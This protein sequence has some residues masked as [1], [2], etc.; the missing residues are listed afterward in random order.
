MLFKVL[1]WLTDY[2]ARHVYT[3]G[4]LARIRTIHFARW[5]LLDGGRTAFFASNYDGSHQAYMDDFINKVWWGLNIVFSNGLGYPRTRWL[6]LD[7]ARNE[8]RFKDTNRRHQIATQ[9]W[10][11]AYPGLT[12]VDLA[13]NTRVRHAFQQA[14]MTD[15]EIRAWLK[16]L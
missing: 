5:V 2:G 8:L 3:T 15:D 9:V 11:K 10:Y 13:R 1:L 16:D 14:A 6:F 4:H 7:G 12:A